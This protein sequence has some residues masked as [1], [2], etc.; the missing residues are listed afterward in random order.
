MLLQS[1]ENLLLLIGQSLLQDLSP[2][3]GRQLDPVKSFTACFFLIVHRS[4]FY[5][6]SVR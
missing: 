3:L 2:I 4:A 1:R 6:H 5:Q